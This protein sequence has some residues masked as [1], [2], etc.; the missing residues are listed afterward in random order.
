VAEE[1][2]KAMDDRIVIGKDTLYLTIIG[3]L[4]VLLAVSIFT[5]GFGI[6]KP[7]TAVNTGGSNTTGGSGSGTGTG[8]TG[9]NTEPAGLATLQL[10]KLLASAPMLGQKDA[11]ITVL[12]FSDFQCPFCGMTWGKEYS[13]NYAAITGTIKKLK[14]NY[15]T[16]NK[17]N[18]VYFPVAFLGQESIDSANAAFCAGD[19]GKFFEM[20]D[21]IFAAQTT[22][23]NNGKYAPAKLKEMGAVI[24]GLDTVTFNA[25]VDSNKYASQVSS[26]TSDWQQMSKSNTGSAGTPTIYVII[27]KAKYSESKV[28][29]AVAAAGYQVGLSTDKTKYV[30]LAD[31]EYA[32]IKTLLDGVLS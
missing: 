32:S 31:P 4:I 19:Q 25:C 27:D 26:F 13:A 3:I 12:E 9:G 10:P 18:F 30:V 23:E 5:S 29:A 22:E 14:D 24:S 15:V 21:A 6:I 7:Q 2:K 11:S 28:T 16:A 20:E 1:T 8:S 17:A